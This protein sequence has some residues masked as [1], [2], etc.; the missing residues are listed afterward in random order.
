MGKGLRYHKWSY[1]WG[2]KLSLS[3][4]CFMILTNKKIL[5]AQNI[6]LY[7]E[8]MEKVEKFKYLGIWLVQKGTWRTHVENIELK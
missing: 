3:K 7:G 6:Q 5:D 8:S 4:S 1:N 2:F